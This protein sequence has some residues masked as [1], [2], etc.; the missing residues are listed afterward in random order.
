MARPTLAR[1]NLRP[2]RD[3]AVVPPDMT[4]QRSA[5]SMTSSRSLEMSR[6]PLP[7]AAA[8]ARRL[9]TYAAARISR[10]RVGWHATR[11]RAPAW[12]RSEP[13]WWRENIADCHG[14]VGSGQRNDEREHGHS[15]TERQRVGH[16]STAIH[17][18]HRDHATRSSGA[19]PM[20]RPTLARVNLRPSR[21]AAVVPP[22]MTTQRSASS[23][24]SSRSLEMSR[25]PLPS[26]AASARRL[27]T[28]AA[29]RISRPRVGWHATRRSPGSECAGQNNPLLIPARERR[30]RC[31]E[32]RSLD[33]VLLTHGLSRVSD[34]LAVSPPPPSEGSAY[35]HAECEVL[36]YREGGNDGSAVPIRTDY[37]YSGSVECRR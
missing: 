10:P 11:R 15:S 5:S 21:D 23:M 35:G 13:G 9:R 24:T 17:A 3:A 27:R 36:G 6:T 16:R 1:V 31:V 2:S 30:Q 29:A 25:T 22:D 4:T 28:Y 18:A 26:A 20:A 7:S 12:L 33:L 32:I 14:R 37:A 19:P 8:S 34:G